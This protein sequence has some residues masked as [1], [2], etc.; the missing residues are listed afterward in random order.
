MYVLHDNHAWNSVPALYRDALCADT[1]AIVL[2]PSF[3][4][5]VLYSVLTQS[6]CFSLFRYS[7]LTHLM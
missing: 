3:S 6:P 4:L 7:V 5:Q 2:V 1:F